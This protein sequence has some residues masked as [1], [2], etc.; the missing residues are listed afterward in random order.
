VT[1]LTDDNLR[2]RSVAFWSSAAINCSNFNRLSYN[3]HS[4]QCLT[5][6]RSS[7][8]FPFLCSLR[9][10][11]PGN[12][13]RC[14]AL[15]LSC[16]QINHRGS[17]PY[18]FRDFQAISCATPTMMTTTTNQLKRLW[19]NLPADHTD[20]DKV[21]N[22]VSIDNIEAEAAGRQLLC[23]E[24]KEIVFFDRDEELWTTKGSGKIQLP[25]DISATIYRGKYLV[26]RL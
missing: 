4:I 15:R 11:L 25:A 5:I 18:T 20:L 24:C 22:Y 19:H 12:Q 16:S 6:P 17:F 1:K 13:L 26:V 8:D 14:H 23:K 7:R 9:F 21:T 3:N 2:L 10:C